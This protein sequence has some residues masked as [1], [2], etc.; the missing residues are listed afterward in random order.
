MSRVIQTGLIGFGVSGHAFHAP[1][2]HTLPQYNLAAIVERHREESKKIYPSVR[3][4]R[5]PEEII[6]DP[7]IELIVITTPNES[8]FPL[9]KQALLAGKHVVIEKPM[10]IQSKDALELVA[11]AKQ[12][13]KIVSPY[14]NRRY[15][16]DFLTVK[17]IVNQNLL[18]DIV[19]CEIHYD[20]YRPQLRPGAWREK[21]IPGSGILYDLGAHLI[22][23]ALCLFGHPKTIT[24]DVRKQRPGV[25]A[26]DYFDLRLDYGW[27]R[28]I[29]CGS[30]L[31]REMGPRYMLHGMKGSFVKSGDDP[32]EPLLRAGVMPVAPDWGVEPEE[33]WGILHTE[34][35]GQVIREKYPSLGGNYGKYYEDLYKAIVGESELKIK[36]KDGYNIIRII[37]LAM[38]SSCEKRTFNCDQ[39]I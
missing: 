27:L 19:E 16:S 17:E 23:Q 30:M 7:S 36:P 24:A 39:L 34:K 3:I 26:D 11:L 21:D 14:Q 20:R 22:D 33:T 8:H 37:E 18:G 9:A 38:Q 31:V 1:F 10:T 6:Q 15:V 4:C 25:E 29:L 35:D 32:Q 13:Q 12:Q 5:S 28:V 2:L